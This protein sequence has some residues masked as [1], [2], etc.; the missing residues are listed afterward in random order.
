MLK[1]LLENIK[2][3]NIVEHIILQ[4]RTLNRSIA[5]LEN[6]NHG[7]AFSSGLAAIDAYNENF[8]SRR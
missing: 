2:D 6:G 3:M 7:L 1:L 5:S 4:E 8:K